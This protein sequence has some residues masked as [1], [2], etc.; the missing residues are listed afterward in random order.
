MKTLKEIAQAAG[1]SMATVSNVINGNYS[2]VSADTVERIQAIIQ[3]TS[4][5]CPFN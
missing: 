3:A 1:V 4:I 5:S 2:R